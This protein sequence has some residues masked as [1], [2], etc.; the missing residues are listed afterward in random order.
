MQF[1][2][3]FLQ[4][5]Q[6]TI[7]RT[8]E[9]LW[10]NWR[11]AW[12]SYVELCQEWLCSSDFII[13]V[14]PQSKENGTWPIILQQYT[15]HVQDILERIF[16]GDGTW[17]QHNT[18]RIETCKHQGSP[19]SRKFKVL[20]SVGQ[21]MT[22]VYWDQEGVLSVD[23]LERGATVNAAAHEAVRERLGTAFR[24]RRRHHGLLTRGSFLHPVNACPLAAASILVLVAFSFG[25][26][27]TIPAMV[28]I[29][30]QVMFAS[31][32]LSWWPHISEWR[33]CVLTVSK[34]ISAQCFFFFSFVLFTIVIWPCTVSWTSSKPKE[35]SARWNGRYL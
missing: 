31:S 34:F 2:K 13:F 35:K 28:L 22:T 16:N 4:E 32:Q 11:M 27:W 17:V 33:G 21:V 26:I 29:W 18:P 23:F 20:P 1:W 12:V 10:T 25:G 3:T 5:I 7:R 8:D 14:A 15:T 19:R 30:R 9:W 24:Y 6:D